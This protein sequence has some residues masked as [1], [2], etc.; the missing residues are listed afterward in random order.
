MSANQDICEN[1][2]MAGILQ[3]DSHE[4]QMGKIYPAYDHNTVNN[5][6]EKMRF[7]ARPEVNV[8][9][10]RAYNVY[11]DPVGALDITDNKDITFNIPAHT[12]H[13]IDLAKTEILMKVQVKKKK[14]E[15]SDST[16]FH[17][18]PG[19]QTLNASIDE[20]NFPASYIEAADPSSKNPL[21]KKEAEF[22][23]PIDAFFQTQWSNIEIIMNDTKVCSTSNDFPYQAYMEILLRTE[24][25]S[26]K[27][28]AYEWLYT[29]NKFSD[30][31]TREEKLNVHPYKS[32]NFGAMKRSRRVHSTN[33]IQLGGRIFTDFF[34]DPQ[35]LLLN[36]VNLSLRLTPAAN[37]FRFNVFP[38]ELNDKFEYV[39]H[40]IQMKVSY[41]VLNDN[42][43]K[44]ISSLLDDSP[45]YYKYVRNDFKYVPMNNG[46]RELKLP[47]LFDRRVPIDLVLAMVDVENHYGSFQKD[48]F[49]FKRNNI[50]L[51]AFYQDNVAIPEEALEFGEEG[52][53]LKEFS[54][55]DQ[56]DDEW[57]YRA[58]KSLHEV[59]G[60][61]DN[62]FDQYNY[63]D[64]NFLICLKTDPT[65]TS[66]V[67]LWPLPKTG[68]TSLFLRFREPIQGQQHLLILARFPAL[69][70]IDKK[71][72]VVV[73]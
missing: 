3:P 13:F 59:A 9:E 22:V 32:K 53:F 18:G 43:V 57:A 25:S 50:E 69:V 42:S 68:N 14:T 33:V 63:R 56:N 44:A 2:K 12:S 45:I 4:S 37:R 28:L 26:K 62:D 1:I 58:L 29:N 16:K 24:E 66:Q 30:S 41:V 15:N 20:V 39:I 36:G 65:V 38:E 8:G 35:L 10:F 40:K 52:Q 54:E 64:G 48:P 70:T 73:W 46:I 60:T 34:K 71:R 19:D 67:D 11:V 72:K 51:A 23:V 55:E 5:V 49:Y 17:R 47:D 21:N 31:A 61:Y 27:K 6:V 7:F